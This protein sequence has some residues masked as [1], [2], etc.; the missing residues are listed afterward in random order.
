MHIVC[1]YMLN[2]TYSVYYVCN[3][4]LPVVRYWLLPEKWK[5]GEPL[6]GSKAR[7]LEN[8]WCRLQVEADDLQINKSKFKGQ[9]TSSKSDTQQDFLSS[10]LHSWFCKGPLSLGRSTVL[11]S[12][13]I[14]ILI[15]SK[16]TSRDTLR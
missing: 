9:R 3:T 8:Q 4:Q 1:K 10:P 16:K 14:C 11:V 5:A 13:S 6:I 12:P 15:S 7:E 2:N